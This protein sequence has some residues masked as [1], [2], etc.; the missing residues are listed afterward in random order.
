M[1]VDIDDMDGTEP[2]AMLMGIKF[3]MSHLKSFRR[4]ALLGDEK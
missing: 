2:G 3:G 4:M 1:L